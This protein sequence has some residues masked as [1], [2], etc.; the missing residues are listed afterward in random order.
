M[1]FDIIKRNFQHRILTTFSQSAVQITVKYFQHAFNISNKESG[2][3]HY[4]NVHIFTYMKML[5]LS[6][7]MLVLGNLVYDSY[8]YF[9]QKNY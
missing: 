4:S 7:D 9:L 5:V 8:L 6:I 1:N 2:Y 3:S